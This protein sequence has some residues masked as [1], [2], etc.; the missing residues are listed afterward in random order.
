MKTKTALLV[1]LLLPL[2]GLSQCWQQI[3]HNI[4]LKTDGSLNILSHTINGLI[5]YKLG[6][7]NDWIGH[8]EKVALKQDGRLFGYRIIGDQFSGFSIQTILLGT[9]ISDKYSSNLSYTEDYNL[10]YAIKTNGELVKLS[11]Q[12]TYNYVEENIGIDNDWVDFSLISGESGAIIAKK[13]N[14]TIWGFGSNYLGSLG[15]GN[16]NSTTQFI[17]IGTDQNWETV[18][19]NNG[20]SI[21]L[22][23]DGTLWSWGKNEDGQL[24]NGT[25][26][27]S[28]IPLQ[29]GTDN[30]WKTFVNLSGSV[31]AMKTNG[32]LWGW[33]NSGF[34]NLPLGVQNTNTA[35]VLLPLQLNQDNDWDSFDGIYPRKTNST[36]WTWGYFQSSWLTGLSNVLHYEIKQI[37]N[38]PFT[39]ISVRSIPHPQVFMQYITN[40]VAQ[41]VDGSLLY[42]GSFSASA[43]SQGIS[44]ESPLAVVSCNQV[45][46][47][48]VN[49]NFSKNLQFYPNPTNSIIN[50][51]SDSYIN[52]ITIFDIGGRILQTLEVVNNQIDISNY[53][54]GI[55]LLKATTTNGEVINC[56]IIKE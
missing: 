26:L 48:L 3:N 1:F 51:S 41:K 9:N 37:K 28:N 27:N 53:N 40:V 45:I 25:T 39:R 6:P 8:K 10:V 4:T 13:S 7:D 33:G 43:Q 35:D 36:Y 16:V 31:Y 21:G 42:Y 32:T 24:G 15:I 47:S 34:Y 2:I 30:S 22:K 19:I 55:Y 23:T 56:K 20:L 17:Q 54:K 44:Y 29:V 5:T 49:N 12:G 14:G 18:V 52:K 46:G 50:I 11:Q 38:I